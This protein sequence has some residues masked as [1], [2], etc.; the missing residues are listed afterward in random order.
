MLR[1]IR[2]T[3]VSTIVV[4]LMLLGFWR[5]TVDQKQR[6]IDE[7]N[8]L[9]AQL[10]QQLVAR[11]EMIDRLSR[12]RRI[13]HVEVLDQERDSTGAAV[14]TTVRFIELGDNGRELGRQDF[15]ILGNVLFIDAWTVKFEP[16]DVAHGDPLRG[17]TLI[18]LRRI[19]SDRMRPLEGLPIDTPGAI[20]AGYAAS[21]PAKFE[22]QL[23]RDFW[24][25]AGD[26]EAA[27]A[28]GIRVA[29]GEAVYQ[30]VA[31]GQR[32]ELIVDNS[33]GMSLTALAVQNDPSA[34][35]E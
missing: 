26:R 35:H 31:P 5:Y 33:G 21:D 14:D 17:K 29:Q 18:L 15:T 4:A 32:F 2:T 3:I 11:Q 23:W 6:S 25:L 20:P 24:R 8:A 34:A 13:G 16:G 28:L 27:E 12:S 10:E 9:K 30:Q 19:Y 22:Q 7:L 1:F